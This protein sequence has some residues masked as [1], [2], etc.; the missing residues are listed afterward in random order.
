MGLQDVD[1]QKVLDG[2]QILDS[3]YEAGFDRITEL[4]RT[5]FDAPAAVI[6][7]IDKD[8]QWFKSHP[9]FDQ[10]QTPLEHAICRFTVLS[11]KAL[12]IADALA[13]E[14]TRDNPYV[15]G[16]DHLRAYAGAPLIAP[17]GARIGTLSVFDRKPRRFTPRDEDILQQLAAIV[18]HNLELRRVA[19]HDWLTGVPGRGAF[20]R[21]SR[22]ILSAGNGSGNGSGAADRQRNALIVFD[23]D[24]FKQLND[25]YGHAAGDEV[26][27]EVSRTCQSSLREQDVFS[28]IGGEEFSVLLPGTAP[29]VAEKVARRLQQRIAAMPRDRLSKYL[30]ETAGITA[31]F[32]VTMVQE[33]EAS[34]KHALRRAD[35]ALYAAKERGRNC[36]VCSWDLAAAEPFY[37]KSQ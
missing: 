14:R 26:L 8:R 30:P 17:G 24:F 34:I 18:M 36:V 21:R 35:A 11:D 3:G 32:G 4:A 7:F 27:K 20:E 13:D 1:R 12:L 37:G 15:T 31:S 9:G 33:G 16:P 28:R 25:T 29:D 22:A 5:I 10:R 2:Y 23:L 6:C 19:D